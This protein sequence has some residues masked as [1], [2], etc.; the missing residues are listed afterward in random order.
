MSKLKPSE[1]IKL[2]ILQ[3]KLGAVV[4]DKKNKT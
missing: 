4:I 3:E 1:R 2:Q